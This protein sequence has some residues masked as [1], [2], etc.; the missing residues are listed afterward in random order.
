MRY[1]NNYQLTETKN[2]AYG[3]HRISQ[4]M[5]IVALMPQ[6]DGPRIHKKTK[7]IITEKMIQNGKTQKLLEICQN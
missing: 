7:K 6:K 2:P 1:L 5:R 3:R 4:P